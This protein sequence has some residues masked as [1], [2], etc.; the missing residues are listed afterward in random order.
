MSTRVYSGFIFKSRKFHEITQQMGKL[1][2]A[3]EALQRRKYDAAFASYLV[4]LVDSSKIAE[5]A[6]QAGL[7]EGYPDLAVERLLR[8]RIR[9]LRASP[10]RDPL[11]DWTLGLKCWWS[12][13]EQA[14]VG[15]L[16]GEMQQPVRELLLSRSIARDFAYWNNSDQPD[17]VTNR[18][19]RRREKV[20]DEVL[21]DKG[22]FLFD[23]EGVYIDSEPMSPAELASWLPTHEDRV[24]RRANDQ[25]LLQWEA[26]LTEEK[27]QQ[28]VFGLV[29][30]F[31]KLI[32][33][34]PVWMAAL[35]EQVARLTTLLPTNEQ[36][37]SGMHTKH[38]LVQ[39]K[40]ED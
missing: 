37:L 24:K 2:P 7:K 4:K 28:P 17:S 13:S 20:W 40:S 23:Y 25:V 21:D 39:E 15:H 32:R 36:L 6:G 38:M 18:E 3:I 34:D 22:H 30:E 8:D 1:V 29:R 11:V 31:D 35:A 14:Y 10:T 27:K 16:Y 33:T 19:W 5:A 12:A 26:T 9:R